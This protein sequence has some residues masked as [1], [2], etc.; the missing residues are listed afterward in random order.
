MPSDVTIRKVKLT[1]QQT[2]LAVPFATEPLLT[3]GPPEEEPG[4][5][6][7]LQL[8]L[9]VP[10][11]A[12]PRLN[13]VDFSTVSSIDTEAGTLLAREATVEYVFDGTPATTFSFWTLEVEYTV[14]SNPAQAIFSHFTQV[15]PDGGLGETSRGTVT[16][17]KRGG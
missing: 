15:N 12:I 7:T 11:P 10:D 16:T 6:Y 8:G 9:Y 17:V 4:N 1:L 2:G 3:V 13:F 5:T 14:N